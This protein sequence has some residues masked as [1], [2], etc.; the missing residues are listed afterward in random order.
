[1]APLMGELRV[2]VL[3]PGGR[4]TGDQLT[5][6]VRLRNLYVGVKPLFS[7]ASAEEGREA[8][9]EII[10]LNPDGARIA[11][12][13]LEWRLVKENRRF[14]WYRDDNNNNLVY[15]TEKGGIAVVKPD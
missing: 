14:Q 3:E 13:G 2:S 8:G 9:F 10:A 7:G 12:K 15:V 5:I 11:A 4:A 1:M 6:P